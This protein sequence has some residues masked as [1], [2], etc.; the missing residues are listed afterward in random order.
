MPG[1]LKGFHSTIFAYGQT[2][3]GIIFNDF[4]FDGVL[5]KTHTI[6]GSDWESLIG[7]NGKRAQQTYVQDIDNDSLYVGV[8]PRMINQ[9]FKQYQAKEFAAK[10]LAIYCS[11]LQIYNEKIYDLLQVIEIFVYSS[12]FVNSDMFIIGSIWE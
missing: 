2:G 12:D 1:V 9:I 11:F 7:Y 10:R 8:I 5:G 3:S 4:F 6:F